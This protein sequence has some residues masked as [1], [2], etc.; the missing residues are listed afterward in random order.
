MNVDF[1]LFLY[2]PLRSCAY[3]R[4]QFCI[5]LCKKNESL[6]TFGTMTQKTLDNDQLDAQIFKY[7]Y[8]NP[9]HVHVSSNILLILRRSNCINTASGIAY[10]QC[11]KL[12]YSNFRQLTCF[13]SDDTSCCI[14]T[15]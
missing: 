3:E 11:S 12:Y 2:T 8:Y 7:I 9:I 1:P 10:K 5:G 6:T 14:N 15:V 4:G 13:Q